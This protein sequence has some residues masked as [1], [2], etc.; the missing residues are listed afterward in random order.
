M[1][2]DNDKDG[3][4][5]GAK[6]TGAPVSTLVFGTGVGWPDPDE[7]AVTGAG[8]LVLPGLKLGNAALS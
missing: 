6:E 2:V 7:F 1:Q 3:N 4:T 5:T 8:E